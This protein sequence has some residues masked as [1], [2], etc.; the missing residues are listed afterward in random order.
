M[1]R[2][3]QSDYDQLA[4]VWEIED[5]KTYA[6][7]KLGTS[8][9]DRK[10]GEY[11]NSTWSFCKFVGNSYHSILDVD[12]KSQ[13]IIKSGGISLEP[14]IDKDGNKQYPKNPQIVIFDWEYYENKKTKNNDDSSFEEEINELPF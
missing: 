7:V 5:K 9:K 13:I 2:L 3:G 4:F 11:K 12:L 10:T 8:R 14:Y 1:W 6:L